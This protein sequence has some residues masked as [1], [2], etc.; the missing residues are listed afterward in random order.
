MEIQVLVRHEVGEH[1]QGEPEA[2]HPALGDAMGGHLQHGGGDSGIHH[3]SARTVDCGRVGRRHAGV[4][5][6]IP[7]ADAEG[8][9]HPDRDAARGERR[10]DQQRGGGLAEGAGDADEPERPGGVAIERTGQACGR[11]SRV[12][13][14]D[15]GDGDVGAAERRGEGRRQLGERD[16][17]GRGNLAGRGQRGEGG[18]E[19]SGPVRYEWITHRAAGPLCSFMPSARSFVPAEQWEDRRHRRGLAGERAAIAYLTACGWELEAHRFRLG[20]H[21]LDLVIRQGHLVAFVEVKTRR[22]MVCGSARESVSALKR[23]RVERVA[24]CWRLRHG[25]PDDVYR[26]DLVAVSDRGGDRYEVEH[27]ADAWRMEWSPC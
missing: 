23:R 8:A 7:D 4:H 18:F 26:F 1:P 13:H 15:A 19:E 17:H 22:S 20:R 5:H 24:L 11:G 27:L 21:D 9:D 2:G 3:L 10:L 14:D 25:R 6:P 12:G 16:R